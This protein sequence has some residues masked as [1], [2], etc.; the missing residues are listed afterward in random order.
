MGGVEPAAPA[1]QAGSENWRARQESNLHVSRSA[2]GCF[3]LFSYVRKGEAAESRD[4]S[5]R[6]Q[7]A[8]RIGERLEVSGRLRGA[9][10]LVRCRMRDPAYVG[11]ATE[12]RTPIFPA[13]NRAS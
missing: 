8:A 5:A 1:L 12:S 3:V 10:Q 9:R 7:A 13:E 6:S 11:A 4:N 2:T